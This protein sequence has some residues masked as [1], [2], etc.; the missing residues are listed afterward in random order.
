MRDDDAEA[1]ASMAIP[2]GGGRN[3][4]WAGIGAESHTAAGGLPKTKAMEALLRLSLFHEPPDTERSV[5][6]C[7][8]TGRGDPASYPIGNADDRATSVGPFQGETVDCVD[9][10]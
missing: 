2:E 3:L 8:R 5:R 1:Y 7:E 6:W 9:T 10:P 4:P